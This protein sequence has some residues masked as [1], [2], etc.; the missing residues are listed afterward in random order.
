[1]T[2]PVL[3]IRNVDPELWLQLRVLATQRRTTTGELLN[4]ILRTYLA[5]ASKNNPQGHQ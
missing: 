3:T 4:E 2:A 1:M 5:T